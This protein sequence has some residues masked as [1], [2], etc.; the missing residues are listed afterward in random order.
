MGSV[1]T[2]NDD[3][4]PLIGESNISSYNTNENQHSR[5][6][7]LRLILNPVVAFD[8][9][10][11]ADGRRLRGGHDGERY[12]DDWC[13][14]VVAV[15]AGGD[16]AAGMAGSWRVDRR[17]GGSVVLVMEKARGGAWTIG[18]SRSGGRECFGARPEILAGD[19][20]VELPTICRNSMAAAEVTD[21]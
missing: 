6:Q 21:E 19:M 10:G 5:P 16:V 1:E 14:E 3:L 20:V 4:E 7:K 12:D 9:D 17:G 11:A 8:D 15:D 18:S 13:G 2:P